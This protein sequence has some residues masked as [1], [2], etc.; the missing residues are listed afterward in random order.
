M[1]ST[2]TT[3][4][5]TPEDEAESLAEH[6]L[7][8]I[9]LEANATPTTMT[10]ARARQLAR[11]VR[12]RGHFRDATP[13]MF[14]V[15]CPECLGRVDFHWSELYSDA[16]FNATLDA[17]VVEHLTDTTWDEG[18]EVAVCPSLRATSL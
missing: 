9:E 14:H 4:G 11:Q 10:K 1:D 3:I 17:A 6:R 13:G 2:D 18:D 12:S 5:I 7:D 16:S 15:N 8:M